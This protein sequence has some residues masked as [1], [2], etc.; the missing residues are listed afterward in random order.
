MKKKPTKADLEK[1]LQEIADR[2]EATKALAI[3]RHAP[4]LVGITDEA[5]AEAVL[6]EITGEMLA[7]LNAT[8]RDFEER[9]LT[10]V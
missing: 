7:E 8:E 2:M 3:A 4:K 10:T 6:A 5:E 1:A 9:G